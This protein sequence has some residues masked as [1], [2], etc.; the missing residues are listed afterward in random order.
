MSAIMRKSDII[1]LT[2]KD[3]ET[4]GIRIASDLDYDAIEIPISFDEKELL[5]FSE[6]V[7]KLYDDAKAFASFGTIIV[8]AKKGGFPFR[9]K[10]KYGMISNNGKLTLRV[11]RRLPSYRA[12]VND[13]SLIDK[14]LRETVLGKK[15]KE[16]WT[17][18]D[19]ISAEE[20][21]K[22]LEEI[23]PAVGMF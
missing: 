17:I 14:C 3:K 9:K 21:Q 23:T 20:A 5:Q 6:E 15:L 22:R 16:Y 1:Q 7:K 8:E 2:N 4:Y 11:E 19:E 10:A 18:S 13:L 12:N